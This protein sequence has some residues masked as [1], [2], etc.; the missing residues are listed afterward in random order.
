MEWNG[1]GVGEVTNHTH[2]AAAP[3]LTPSLKAQEK[4]GNIFTYFQLNRKWKSR[5]SCRGRERERH[6][7][8]KVERGRERERESVPRLSRYFCQPEGG[9][10]AARSTVSHMSGPANSLCPLSLTLPLQPQ[11]LS[12]RA[13]CFVGLGARRAANDANGLNA[14]QSISSSLRYASSPSVVQ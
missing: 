3:S 14:A 6:K 12:L 1:D 7:E 11:L 9:R 8:R 4:K 2:A 10:A 5:C 13:A